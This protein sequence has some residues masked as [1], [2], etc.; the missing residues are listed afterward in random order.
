MAKTVVF[1]F[2]R[3]NPPTIGHE[4]LVNKVKAIAKKHGGEPRLYLS[5]S[6]DKKKNPLDYNLKSSLAQ[7]A[8]GIMKKSKAKHAIQIATEISKNE[9]VDHLVMVV[10]SDRLA[11]FKKLLNNYNGKDY[12][13]DKISVE[14][15]G[16]RDPD[17]EGVEGMSGT[18]LRNLAVDGDMK[19][20]FDGL[21]SKL[22]A[23]DKKK[24]YDAVRKTMSEEIDFDIDLTDADIDMY[25]IDLDFLDNYEVPEELELFDLSDLGEES[26]LEILNPVQR[27]EIARRMKRLAPKLARKREMA[28]KRMAKPAQLVKR[29]NAAAVNMLRKKMAG[30]LGQN[31]ANLSPVQKMSVDKR[32]E[33]KKA[34]FVPK[35]RKKL[36]PGIRKAE[37]ERLA[38]LRGKASSVGESLDFGPL[39]ERKEEWV[40]IDNKNGKLVKTFKSEKEAKAFKKKN[41]KVD[42]ISKADYDMMNEE[43]GLWHNI[44]KKRERGEKM[45]KKGD[46][47]APTDADF[48]AASEKFSMDEGRMKELHSL[49]KQGKS[50]EDIAKKMKLDVKTIKALMPEGYVYSGYREKFNYK[51]PGMFGDF[52]L[53]D[54]DKG[55]YTGKKKKSKKP[56]PEDDPFAIDTT[57]VDEARRRNAG[58]DARAALRRDKDLGKRGKDSADKDDAATDDDVEAG[59]KNIIMQLRKVQSLRGLKPVEFDDGK[60]IKINVN[61]AVKAMKMYNQM[62]T[63]IQKGDFMKKLSKSHKEF[64]KAIGEDYNINQEA[65]ILLGLAKRVERS[66]YTLDEL[67]EMFLEGGF[68]HIDVMIAEAKKLKLSDFKVGMFVQ[69]KGGKV[70]KITANE[71]RGDQIV[72]KWNKG[73]TDELPIKGLGL[74]T[75]PKLQGLVMGEE[76]DLDEG[77]WKMPKNKKQIAPLLK[78]MRKPVKLGKDG[79]DAAKVV[80]PYIGDDELEDDLYDAGKKNPNGDARPAIR[81]ALQRFGLPWEEEVEV[82]EKVKLPRQ[83]IDPKKEVMVVKKSKVIVIDIKDKDSYIKKGWGIAEA[84]TDEAFELVHKKTG[85]KMK[86]KDKKAAL[87]MIKKD[88]NLEMPGHTWDDDVD[89]AAPLPTKKQQSTVDKIKKRI[90]SKKK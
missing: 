82:D 63:S 85:K 17:A 54:P 23:K 34:S 69:G 29:A 14:N 90:A 20:F 16:Q 60:K 72:V 42:I 37:K 1:T 46:P 57:P 67:K 41:K 10:G 18:K 55:K 89:E 51:I 36:M 43:K 31:Y 6:Q 61:Q 25:E 68:D 78:L 71:P 7:K 4:K 88:K 26:L 30:K 32:I 84:D 77:T 9:D 5:H 64:K 28:K 83:L 21:P 75:K 47:G 35:M 11:E 49:I 56:K 62:R 81:D 76:V 33:K 8:F 86:V 27:K 80:A 44:H 50:A 65:K 73:G 13:F 24:I 38:S 2:G 3:M 70:G 45:R 15:A 52:I 58:A 87:M 19:T 59:G 53:G 40:A 74:Y 39:I 12:N 48:K 22:K 79:D 66:D